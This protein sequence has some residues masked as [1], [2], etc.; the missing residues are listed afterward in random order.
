MTP[1]RA[2]RRVLRRELHRSRSA[3]A[4]VVL[5]LLALGAVWFGVESVLALLGRPALLARPEDV[6][7][8]A[9]AALGAPVAVLIGVAVVAAVLGVVAL[10]LAIGPGRRARHT[11]PHER[12]LVVVDDGVLA[13]ALARTARTA[14]ALGPDRA[15]AWVSR[16]RA[17]VRLTPT[18]GVEVPVRDVEAAVTAQLEAL[19]SVPALQARVVTSATGQV[20]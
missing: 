8:D 7:A 12:L 17:A 3:P 20:A 15:Q 11:V 5:V 9:A 6:P 4:V 1:A 2:D 14:A 16:R 10:A 13:S 18:A 19:G